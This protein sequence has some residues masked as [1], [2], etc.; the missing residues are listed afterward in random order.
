MTNKVRSKYKPLNLALCISPFFSLNDS[1]ELHVISIKERTMHRRDKHL[2]LVI[3]HYSK[4]GLTAK[5]VGNLYY[6]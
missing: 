4:T 1:R 6:T 3:S 5:P 2:R